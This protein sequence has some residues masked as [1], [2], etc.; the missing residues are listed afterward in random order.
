MHCIPGT[1]FATDL[2]KKPTFEEDTVVLLTKDYTKLYGC[3]PCN[4]YF[5]K[6]Q[7]VREMNAPFLAM[8][9]YAFEDKT[10]DFTKKSVKFSGAM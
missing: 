5:K 6:M 3:G 10:Q 2:Q 4:K 1:I 8:L 7:F 9:S